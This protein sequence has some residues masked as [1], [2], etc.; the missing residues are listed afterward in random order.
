MNKKVVQKQAQEQNQDLHDAWR[1][2]LLLWRA[3]QL[4]FLDE[5]AVNETTL[6]RRKGW[7]PIG[8]TA[9]VIWP[10][11]RSECWSI[12]SAYGQ[13]GFITH[14][15]THGSF[16][17]EMFNNFVKYNLLPLC[18]PFQDLGALL[19]LIIAEYTIMM[20]R[21]FLSFELS[22]A[23]YSIGYTTDLQ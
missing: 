6:Q 10:F 7:A 21:S 19:L 11:K 17:A 12:L 14:D 22:L 15:I 2:K 4:V 23:N 1:V 9:S 16:T 20:S 5:S 18:S 8:A 3:H 13:E